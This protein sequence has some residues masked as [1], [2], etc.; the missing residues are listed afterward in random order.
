MVRGRSLFGIYDRP[1]RVHRIDFQRG[2]GWA[3]L[4]NRVHP[5][6]HRDTAGHSRSGPGSEP[7]VLRRDG[8]CPVTWCRSGAPEQ[9]WLRGQAAT[10]GRLTIA[11]SVKEP[12]VSRLM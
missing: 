9:H 8:S 2:L 1:Y 6:L 12:R 7:G 10:A 3:V 11:V 4:T 5:T